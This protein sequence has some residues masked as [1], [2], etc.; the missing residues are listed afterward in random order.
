M[1]FFPHASTYWPNIRC[2]VLF[3]AF[4][5]WINATKSISNGDKTHKLASPF[6][7]ASK[8]TPRIQ[9]RMRKKE[10]FF[11]YI[12]LSSRNDIRERNACVSSKKKCPEENGQI[13]IHLMKYKLSEIYTVLRSIN[14]TICNSTHHI[15]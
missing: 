12:T 14:Q 6:S 11:V 1:T 5:E 10:H 8:Q 4:H 9:H 2:K 13:F 15:W 7:K 3:I